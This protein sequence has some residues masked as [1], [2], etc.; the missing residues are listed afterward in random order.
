MKGIIVGDG[1]LEMFRTMRSPQQVR[2]ACYLLAECTAEGAIEVT[3]RA[4]AARLGVSLASVQEAIAAMTDRGLLKAASAYKTAST[5]RVSGVRRLEIADVD[6]EIRVFDDAVDDGEKR[7]RARAVADRSC[8]RPQSGP[9][10]EPNTDVDGDLTLGRTQNRTQSR[11]RSSSSGSPAEDPSAVRAVAGSASPAAENQGYLFSS[12]PRP[13]PAPTDP[14]TGTPRPESNLR[15]AKPARAKTQRRDLPAPA[16]AAAD[17]LRD[18]ILRAQ[19]GHQIRVR[20]PWDENALRHSWARD[21]DVIV[22]IDRRAWADVDSMIRWV[23]EAQ[24]GEYRF[25]VESPN[26]LRTKWDKIERAM[27]RPV[28]R[29]DPR[30]EIAPS[31][32][33]RREAKREERVD[34]GAPIRRW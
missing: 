11:S 4:L 2:V 23:W 3:R 5:I 26:A 24:T 10:T 28:Q 25:E 18:E 9:N 7:E 17:L 29:A 19:P 34:V 21:F 27:R 8:V 30:D 32:A 22:R 14:E 12:P 6:T 15:A 16:F 20:V 1:W 33:P 31:A 13:A